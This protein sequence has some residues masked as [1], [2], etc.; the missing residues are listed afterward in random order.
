VP[1]TEQQM[2]EAIEQLSATSAGQR[3][4]LEERLSGP[5][6]SVLALCDGA[7]LLVLP[8]ARD[9]KRLMDGDQGPN[10]G[11]MGAIAPAVLDEE[12]LSTIVE[13]CMQPVVDALARRGTPFCGALYAGVMLTADGPRILEFNARFGD[14]ETQVMM[15][16]LDG[17]LLAAMEACTRGALKPDMLTWKQGAAVCRAC[18]TWVPRNSAT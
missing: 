11:G 8:P 7:R 12:Q 3:I 14:P 18:C 16:L 17:D 9:H 1:E 6:I 4:I 2:L 10:T 15:P 5:E 13:R